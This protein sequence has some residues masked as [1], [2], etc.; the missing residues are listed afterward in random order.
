MPF[1]NGDSR[2]ALSNFVLSVIIRAVE[3]LIFLTH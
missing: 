3:A 2:L 1:N